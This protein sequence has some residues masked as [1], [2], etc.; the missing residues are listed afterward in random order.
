MQEAATNH[1]ITMPNVYADPDELESYA[2]ALARQM[3]E[4]RS[5][6]SQIA[7]ALGGV[8]SWRDDK[9]REFDDSLEPLLRQMDQV[10]EYAAEDLIP[11]LHSR[12]DALRSYNG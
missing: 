9:R 12:V 7:S 1:S 2:N 3:E 11:W 5:L 10:A 4:L 6:S 8:E